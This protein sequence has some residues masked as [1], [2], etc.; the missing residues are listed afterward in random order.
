MVL[1]E[2]VWPYWG[3]L[4]LLELNGVGGV[5]LILLEWI[6]LIYNYWASWSR[7][8]LAGRSVSLETSLLVK[9][10]VYRV[11]LTIARD[12]SSLSRL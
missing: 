3:D 7:C 6:W 8:G 4:A 12:V 9:N 5:G 10:I 1:M 2:W 11:N